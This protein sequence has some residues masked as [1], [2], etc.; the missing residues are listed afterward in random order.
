M[1]PDLNLEASV[2]DSDVLGLSELAGVKVL[3]MNLFLLSKVRV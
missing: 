3:T 2:G 1:S